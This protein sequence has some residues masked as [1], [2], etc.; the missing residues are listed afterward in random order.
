VRGRGLPWVAHMVLPARVAI[1]EEVC[2]RGY[3]GGDGDGRGAGEDARTPVSAATIGCLSGPG[4]TG[5]SARAANPEGV[6]STVD[7]WEV[8]RGVLFR[9]DL[10]GVVSRV[11][12]RSVRYGW[13]TDYLE[14]QGES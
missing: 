3:N 8:V 11:T 12:R 6:R 5:S 2:M 1:G 7:M 14:V 10:G 4:S 9:D 13:M